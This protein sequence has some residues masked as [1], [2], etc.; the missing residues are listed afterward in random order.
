MAS[1]LFELKPSDP[2]TY[3]AVSLLLASVAA[4]ASYV[5]ARRAAAIDANQALRQE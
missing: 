3:G 5:P 1:M 4:L 2:W